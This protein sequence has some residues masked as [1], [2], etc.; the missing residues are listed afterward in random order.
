MVEC[1]NIVKIAVENRILVIAYLTDKGV[2]FIYHYLSFITNIDDD[3][4]KFNEENTLSGAL[5]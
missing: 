3:V 4:C 5:C 2:D 1:A